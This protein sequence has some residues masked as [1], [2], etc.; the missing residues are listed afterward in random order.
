MSGVLSFLC[1]IMINVD[2][3]TEEKA[4]P[5]QPKSDQ[6]QFM[7]KKYYLLSLAFALT[8]QTQA[9]KQD[10]M[11]QAVEYL[12]SQELGGRYPGT[13]GDTLASDFITKQLRK[14]KLKPVLNNIENEDDGEEGEEQIEKVEVQQQNEFEGEEE[15]GLL[16]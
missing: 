14:L 8:L 6:E 5:L 15:Q 1:K 7:K 16:S 12:A 9:Q 4:V 10:D 2:C 3:R 11:R 13:V